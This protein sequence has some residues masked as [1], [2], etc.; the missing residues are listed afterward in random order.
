VEALMVL[1]GLGL[2]GLL[3]V[4]PILAVV[5]LVRTSRLSGEIQRL[6]ADLAAVEGRLAGLVRRVAPARPSGAPGAPGVVPPGSAPPSVPTPPAAAEP[7]PAVS[8]RAPVAARTSTGAAAAGPSASGAADRRIAAG[9]G[10]PSGVMPGATVPPPRPPR[11]PPPPAP[12]AGPAFDWESLLGVRGAAWLGGITLVIASVFFAKWAIDSGYV[13]PELRIATL[14]LAGA[15]GLVW[16]ELSLRRGYAATAN[17]VSGA[18]IAIL[19]VAFFAAHSLYGL[20]PLSVTFAMMAL[21][22]VVAGVV[23]IR[24]DAVFTAVLGLLGGFATPL[25]L[26]TGQ[27][28]PV[29]LF[30][31]ILILNLG[32]MAVARRRRW[33]GLVLLGLAGTLVVELGWFG[34]FMA[35][36]KMLVGLAAFLLFGVLY[37]FLPLVSEDQEQQRL[38][39]AGSIGGIAPFLFALLLAGRGAYVAEWPLLFGYLGLLSV[40]LAAVAL[41][42]G[43]VA[44]L[45]AGALATALTLPIWAAQGLAPERS[46]GPALAA[47]VL[48]AILNAP[49]RAARRL[50][51]GVAAEQGRA[52]EA[53]GLVAWAGLGLFTFVLVARGFGEPPWVFLSLAAALTVLLVERTGVDRLPASLLLGSG[54]L[55]LLVQVWFFRTTEPETLTRNLAVPLLLVAALSVASFVR[56]RREPASADGDEDEAGAIA[57]TLAA[58]AGLFGCIGSARLGS[59]PRP[60]FAA[61]GVQVVLLVAS[62][63]R[64]DS[65]GFVLV[66]LLA[67]AGFAT[68]WHGA[69]FGPGDLGAALPAYVAFYLAFLVLPL[70]VP[71]S[72]AESWRNGATP[73]VASA[74][75][76]PA[77]FP[78]L[79]DAVQQGWGKAW[80]GALPVLMAAASTAT[81]YGVSREFTSRP[82]DGA[83]SARRLRYLALFAAV[84]LGFVTVAIPIQLDRQWITIGWALEGAALWWLYGRL[85]HPG[86]KWF[87]AA[88]FA[89][90][91]VRLLAN[92]AVFRYEERGLPVLNWLL[93]TYGVPALACFVGAFLLRRGAGRRAEGEPDTRILSSGAS[94]LGLVLLFALISL[95][96]LDFYSSGRYL[97]LD[98]GRRLKRDLTLSVAWGVYAL[99]LLVLG[100]WRESR[101]LRFVSLGFL[102]LTVAKVFLY[103]LAALEGLYRIL[104]FL[105]LGVSLILVSLLYQRF[106]FSREA[107]T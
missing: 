106:V 42:R 21:V 28:N 36:E 40:A 105:G 37:L 104:S 4:S 33:H 103:D 69:H 63:L 85:P 94:L 19:Y 41:F 77:F 75:A 73:W 90:V 57:A 61:L 95:E 76:G 5:A 87:G 22:T 38:V 88:L 67:S 8:A 66:A 65:P 25:L 43:R 72:V 84:A 26:S 74:L 6:E 93:Y 55:A 27:D 64:R 14:V 35:P 39:Q 46:W 16:A 31:Y 10:A 86:L 102:L 44:L 52:L 96:I 30:S 56:H 60:L 20:L 15:G 7:P 1:M 99:G 71:R 24:Y 11:T 50:A 92:P 82:G 29:G 12:P 51:P 48:A 18:G 17:A 89:L 54:S 70:A 9:T 100:M 49:A 45:V 97:E 98:L 34:R 47:V 81:L 107:S 3:L 101:A 79:Y 78:V 13:T 62:S 53:A 58:L 83:A 80:I 23:A 91:G 59:D 68:V 32:L 2:V